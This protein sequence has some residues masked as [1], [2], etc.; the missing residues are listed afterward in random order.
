[1]TERNDGALIARDAV[2][3]LA[4]LR[5]RRERE[6]EAINTQIAAAAERA[7]SGLRLHAAE[8]HLEDEPVD[9][10]LV[11]DLYWDVPEVKVDEIRRA[12]GVRAVAD[13]I[14][15]AGPGR[16]EAECRGGCGVT[17]VSRATSRS[18]R[19][20][21]H[22]LRGMRAG[23]WVGSDRYCADCNERIGRE[24]VEHRQ[25]EREVYAQREAELARR[26]AALRDAG[27]R[28]VAIPS[29]FEYPSMPG[30]PIS[31]EPIGES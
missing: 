22:S 13:V 28:P 24:I 20:D 5:S 3:E 31:R 14:A 11:R 2:A 9:R 23:E 12:I 1:M 15:V 8:R 19:N 16:F 6:L 25:R 21:G 30:V 10:G 26:I 27:E 4:E 17:V 7:S 18:D 29:H